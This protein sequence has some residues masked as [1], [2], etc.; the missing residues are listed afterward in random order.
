MPRAFSTLAVRRA[1]NLLVSL[2][3]DAEYAQLI[4]HN[5]LEVHSRSVPG[6]VY[7]VPANSGQVTVYQDGRAVVRLCVVPT[8]A[9][10]DDDVSAMHKLM[11]EGD[12]REYLARANPFTVV[13]P[14]FLRLS[15]QRLRALFPLSQ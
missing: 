12:E 14:D 4:T 6:R 1:H 3:T 10:P 13:D 5:Y 7:R 9:M 8:R 2:L 11:I 15:Q